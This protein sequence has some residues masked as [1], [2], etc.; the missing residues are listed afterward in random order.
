MTVVTFTSDFGYQDYYAA[1]I[2][3]AMLQR[4]MRLQFVDITHNIKNYDIVQ[5]AFIFKNAW[6]NFPK[7]TIH[8]LSINDFD[9]EAKAFLAIQHQ[10][11]YFIGPDNGLFWLI[12]EQMPEEVYE[13]PPVAESNFLLKDIYAEAVRHITTQKVFAKIG[14]KR[15]E[16]VQRISLQPV[17]SHAQ[18]RGSVIHIDNYDNVMVNISRELFQQVGN[19]RPFELYFKRHDPVIRLCQHYH[20]VPVGEVLCL[21]NS[22]DCLE[23]AINMG[24]AA[25]L[26]GLHV[27]DVVQIDFKNTQEEIS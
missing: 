18:I 12:F 19:N 10:G 2:K 17:I 13:L 26:L 7:G 25:T 5:A 1:I 3:G 9:G 8:V 20:D 6:Q 4:Q 22:A 15:E 21:F 11:H 14:T 16:I 27:E 24:R 23:I